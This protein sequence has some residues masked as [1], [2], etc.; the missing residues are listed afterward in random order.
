MD[1]VVLGIDLSLVGLGLCAIPTTW[2]Y[3]RG[4]IRAVTLSYPLHKGATTRE[5]VKRL[6]VLSRDVAKFA[7]S[8]GA[9]HAWMESY[10]FSRNTMAHS[11]G[12]LG[13]VVRLG[14]AIACRLDVQFANQGSARK[15]VYGQCPPRG[16][17][18]TERKAWL[19]EPLL[20][21]GLKLDD[22]NQG[23]AAVVAMWGLNALGA[24]CLD[25]LVGAPPSQMKRPR[26]KA[27]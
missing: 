11:L 8:V 20:R 24:P 1:S 6:H 10:A 7:R 25:Y 14:L 22:H 4:R 3:D 13:G 18:D 16:M 2:G 23:D 17:S 9:T 19:L 21:A 27:A 15:L 5:Q 26:R 12:E